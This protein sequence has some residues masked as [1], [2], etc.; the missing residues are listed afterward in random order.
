MRICCCGFCSRRAALVPIDHESSRPFPSIPQ[1]SWMT[2]IA[3]LRRGPSF[4][5]RLIQLRCVTEFHSTG[6]VLFKR[7]GE[8][9][10][11]EQFH[12][13]D[14]CLYPVARQINTDDLAV[15][16]DC[17]TVLINQLV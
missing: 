12:T 10:V 11:A 2:V 16:A 6:L 15:P 17:K 1:L 7:F 13:L 4:T 8:F 3:P 14:Q 9:R 5:H